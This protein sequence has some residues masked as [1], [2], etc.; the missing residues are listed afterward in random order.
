M[1]LK[2]ELLQS[3]LRQPRNQG[4]TLIE[5]LVVL[6]IVGI[7]AAI[8]LPNLLRQV[9]KSREVDAK[10]NLGVIARAQQAY[11]FEKRSFATSLDALT[12]QGTFSSDYYSFSEPSSPGN[13]YTNVVK[14]R[15]VDN[16]SGKYGIRNYAAG[17]YFNAGNYNILL[18]QSRDAG[19][20]VEAPDTSSGMCTN[21]GELIN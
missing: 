8:A 6:I 18:C 10:N 20:D 17:I 7:L 9:D 2:A 5:L 19:M 15:A 1:I 3:K 4:F 11:H 21:N 16:S 12:L 13:N 14:H